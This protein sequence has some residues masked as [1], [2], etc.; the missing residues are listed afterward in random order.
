MKPRR[1]FY[2]IETI[3]WTPTGQ[4]PGKYCPS[5]FLFRELHLKR[6]GLSAHFFGFF[7]PEDQINEVL[8]RISARLSNMAAGGTHRYRLRCVLHRD[9]RFRIT[10]VDAI[11][12]IEGPVRID[13]S[14]RVVDPRDEFL[15][16][17]TSRRRLF[18]EERCRLE[19]K[20][21]FE[22]IFLNTKGELTQGTITNLF[23]DMGHGP[24]LTPALES[25]LLPGVLREYL[26]GR[27]KSRQAILHPEDLQKARG[28]FVGN[29]VR[30][31]LRAELS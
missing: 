26:L 16:H 15:Y 17:K 30:G 5:G 9:G 19:K 4:G 23:L 7:F 14:D 21:F 8:D 27:G 3:G 22:T 6:L 13:I 1:D 28:I 25:G 12:E 18:D 31:L 20:G 11:K 24:L 2:L 10:S 29:S